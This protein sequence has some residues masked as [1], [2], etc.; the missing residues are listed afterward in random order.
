MIYQICVEL[1]IH[2]SPKGTTKYENWS[3]F[4]GTV[5]WFNWQ[6]E[7]NPS[8]YWITA[9]NCRN[10]LFSSKR[11]ASGSLVIFN[12]KWI[13]VVVSVRPLAPFFNGWLWTFLRKRWWN[14]LSCEDS[15][16]ASILKLIKSISQ[17]K[18]DPLLPFFFVYSKRPQS[19]PSFQTI[20]T[21][22]KWL[23]ENQHCGKNWCQISIQRKTKFNDKSIRRNLSYIRMGKRPRSIHLWD[24][25]GSHCSKKKR[26][27]KGK[28][29]DY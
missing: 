9:R 29:V 21:F 6:A 22:I 15:L 28:K 24:W 16:H 13:L 2:T 12:V 8:N 26:I 5:N 19:S 14:M 7:H 4:T 27:R 10:L 1:Y 3:S 20:A 25:K 17:I 23:S 18:D 11:P